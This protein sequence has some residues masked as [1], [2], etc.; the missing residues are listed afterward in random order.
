VAEQEEEEEKFD[1]G[2]VSDPEPAEEEDSPNR[3]KES[4][5]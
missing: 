5:A 3:V 1:D 4:H 2:E